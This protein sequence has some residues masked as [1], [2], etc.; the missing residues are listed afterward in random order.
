MS[1]ETPQYRCAGTAM[2]R[3]PLH[4]FRSLPDIPVAALD[5]TSPAEA[6]ELTDWIRD[7]V[8]RDAALHEAIQ[9]SSPPL[10]RVLE[11]VVSGQELPPRRARRTAASLA[12]Y[13]LRMHSRS[14][15]FG[16]LAG[17]AT[18]TVGTGASAQ[19]HGR[20]R[21]AASIDLGWL[22][23]WV[24]RC[25][26][27]P[28]VLAHL[29]VAVNNLCRIR[30]ERLVLPCG[31]T[32][33]GQPAHTSVRLSD[34]VRLV[35]DSAR[36][37]VPVHRLRESIGKRH[38]RVP[39]AVIDSLLRRLVELG[40]LL[41]E[42]PPTPGAPDPVGHVLA[43]L[44]ALS[45]GALPSDVARE[46]DQLRQVQ[47]DLDHYGQLPVGTGRDVLTSAQ[48]CLRTIGAVP[49]EQNIQV[50]LA[51]GV[52]VQ[53]PALVAEEVEA[54]ANV[55]SRLAGPY[56]ALLEDFHRRFVRRFGVNTPIPVKEVLDPE[57]G[58]D[59]P[60]TRGL[61][62]S[63]VSGQENRDRVLS[64][65]AQEATLLRREVVLDESSLAELSRP[66]AQPP[67]PVEV[68][69]CAQLLAP[70]PDAL[71]SGDF[72]LVVASA[73]GSPSIGAMTSRFAHLFQ[74]DGAVSQVGPIRAREDGPHA[75]RAHLVFSPPHRRSANVLRGPEWSGL[76]IPLGTY[77]D[78]RDPA[79]LDPN[80]L[81]VVA[82]PHRL[83][84]CSYS[85]EQEVIPVGLHSLN[86]RSQAP[87]L[88]RLLREIG[89][90]GARPWQPWTWGAA[91]YLPY[92]PRVRHR[93]TILAPARWRVP[94]SL[95][96]PDEGFSAWERT[97]NRWR[98][99]WRVPDRIQV[100][101]P[102][103]SRDR[104]LMLDLGQE[105][106]RYLF[107][108]EVLHE[109]EIVVSECLAAAPE[110]TGWLAGRGNEIVFP[111]TLGT[112]PSQSPAPTVAG[113]AVRAPEHLPGGPWL[114]AQVACTPEH[115]DDLITTNLPELLRGLPVE[116]WFFVRYDDPHPHLRLRFRGVPDTLN[117]DVLPR[118]SDWV[119]TLRASGLV[120]RLELTTYAP[121]VGRYGP[122]EAMTAAERV[123]DA[124][125]AS[126]LD[127]SRIVRTDRADI[128]LVLLAAA[129]FT[130]IAWSFLGAG[131]ANWF[132]MLSKSPHHRAFQAHRDLA[133][134]LVDP[135]SGWSELRGVPGGHAVVESWRDRRAALEAYRTR[136]DEGTS[137]CP[138]PGQVLASLLHMHSNRLL[139]I[140]R[141]SE[142]EAMAVARATVRA[143]QQRAEKCGWP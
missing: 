29:H 36:T 59:P 58:L 31:H 52:S 32:S 93:R 37:P 101:A 113:A 49:H 85:R 21:K 91:A 1:A 122:G 121:E 6:R 98:D 114:S 118:L 138:A 129:N 7:T 142:A 92:L 22:D 100:L 95:R 15:P 28:A 40:F 33:E 2:L 116:R 135:A 72:L 63:A 64:A 112:T 102:N 47:K 84:V 34:P 109:K 74:G 94:A 62:H 4:P 107:R 143:H 18:A 48:R 61:T 87:P 13:L 38:P 117:A 123:F 127:Q 55:L 136:L 140:D 17:V 54:T 120:D 43:V 81:S 119:A 83:H 86:Y 8:T 71:I 103:V 137:G 65:L 77:S 50:D 106:H 46:V 9:I 125:S 90:G 57:R 14:T 35:L 39:E 60:W 76:T 69:L 108:N 79:V 111:L 126:V 132:A 23:S 51:L 41:T 20:H 11:Q 26:S 82:S 99:T 75:P 66:A 68:E 131:A 73:F 42:L 105:S 70:S 80:D 139:G 130:D 45:P 124:D 27:Q 56:P 78:P 141:E 24:R 25:Q 133:L 88:A 10:A 5:R 53:L 3:A 134:T 115:M 12:R 44:E 96:T 67:W 97:L 16:T 110:A 19:W 89:L 128:P 30:G 104:C